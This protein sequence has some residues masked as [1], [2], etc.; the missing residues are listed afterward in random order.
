M[1]YIWVAQRVI[2]GKEE[3]MASWDREEVMSW[4][5]EGVGNYWFASFPMGGKLSVSTGMVS[6]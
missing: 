4:A 5:H 6:P 1:T 2:D 3:R